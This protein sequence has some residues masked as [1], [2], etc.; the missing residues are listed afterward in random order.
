[1]NL[2]FRTV[3]KK[4]VL[5]KNRANGPFICWLMGQASPLIYHEGVLLWESANRFAETCW[6]LALPWTQQHLWLFSR[7]PYSSPAVPCRNRHSRVRHSPC[8]FADVLKYLLFSIDLLDDC[9][10]V[11]GWEIFF[12]H[13]E[14]KRD[15]MKYPPLDQRG[16]ACPIPRDTQGQVGPGSEHLICL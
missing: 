15:W 4:N 6:G 8:V 5:C 9:I 14:H 16:G 11:G 2:T 7:C 3:H 1:M 13:S 10:H 12:F